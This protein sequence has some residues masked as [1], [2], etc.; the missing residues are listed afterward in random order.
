MC[1][2]LALVL[3]LLL[4]QRRQLLLPHVLVPRCDR[5]TR[6]IGRLL[7]RRWLLEPSF[8]SEWVFSVSYPLL[9]LGRIVSL[10]C[11]TPNV[12][13]QLSSSRIQ[14]FCSSVFVTRSGEVSYW[15]R[16]QRGCEQSR[17]PYGVYYNIQRAPCD[18]HPL[19][20][21]ALQ[22]GSPI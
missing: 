2:K 19:P 11:Q 13:A 18:V 12:T 3:C 17:V 5:S 7:R 16:E 6:A 8:A 21:S 15:R 10:L 14:L 1:K 20:A 4:L 22:T 9:V